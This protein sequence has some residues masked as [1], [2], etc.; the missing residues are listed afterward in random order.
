MI[1]S[2]QTGKYTLKSHVIVILIFFAITCIITFPVI[3]KF[4]TEFAGIGDHPGGGDIWHSVWNFWWF[5][6]AL[7]ND[8][9]PLKTNYIFYPNTVTI[10]QH[11]PFAFYISTVLVQFLDYVQ[12][13]NVLWL[14]G[15]VFGGYGC[16]LLANHFNKNFFASLI[17]GS[18]FTFG[19]Y[20]TTHSVVH[21]GLTTIVWI[22]LSI[23]YLFKISESPSKLN[24]VLAGVFLFLAFLSHLYY[25]HIMI[26]FS[27]V[28]FIFYFL[29]RKQISNK[30]FAINSL[31]A[32]SIALLL[33]VPQITIIAQNFDTNDTFKRSVDEHIE[34]SLSLQNVLLASPIHSLKAPNHDF[35]LWFSDAYVIPFDKNPQLEQFVYLGIIPLVLSGIAIVK[36]RKKRL[37]FWILI[38]GIFFILSLGPELKI[39]GKSEEIS[40]PWKFF[41]ETIP[42]WDFFRVPARSIIMVSLGTAILSSFTVNECLKKYFKTTKKMIIFSIGILFLV[43]LEFSVVPYPTSHQEIPSVYESI[44]NDPRDIAVLE[45]PIGGAGDLGLFSDAIFQYYQIFHEKPIIGGYESRPP[46]NVLRSLQSYF[47]NQFVWKT[48]PDDIVKQ[49]LSEVGVSIFNYYNIG[50]VIIHKKLDWYYEPDYIPPLLSTLKQ[51][52]NEILRVEKP[53]FENVDLFAYKIPTSTSKTPFIILDTGWEILQHEGTALTRKAGPMSKIIL[54]NPDLNSRIVNLEIQLRALGNAQNIVISIENAVLLEQIIPPEQVTVL[55]KNIEISPGSNTLLIAS[56]GFILEPP[57]SELENERKSSLKF[58]SV[59]FA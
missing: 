37:L 6:Y 59:R 3:I 16:F 54:V 40:L 27:I 14:F 29:R 56:D 38:I 5:N 41:Y 52:M 55:V 33:T 23:L 1:F 44:K 45:A 28:F 51:Q 48:T 34:Y 30:T 22:P 18:I 12:T 8:L 47:L 58:Y 21:I 11:H 50:Y 53:D 57:Y 39:F 20:H 25:L 49:D 26:I 43:L 31:I 2:F 9:D 7:K 13:W 35:F 4:N 17:A 15:F 46:V 32:V 24:S 19:T 36:F 10:L 42:G